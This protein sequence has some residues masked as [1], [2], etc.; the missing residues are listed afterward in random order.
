MLI[1]RKDLLTQDR[2]VETKAT[3]CGGEGHMEGIRLASRLGRYR[4]DDGGGARTIPHVVL[5]DQNRP[6]ICLL[7]STSGK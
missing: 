2:A 7:R 1:D 4:G 5:D 3:L 6:A